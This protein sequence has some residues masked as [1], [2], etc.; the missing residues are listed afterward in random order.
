VTEFPISAIEADWSADNIE[1]DLIKQARHDR[2]AF[3][4]LY[5]RHYAPIA[6]YVYHRVGDAHTSEDL[7][8]EVFIAAM[9]SIRRYRHRG[10]P[11]RSWL[12][13]IATNTVNRWA[14][15]RQRANWF[16]SLTGADHNAGARVLSRTPPDRAGAR[17]F[18]RTASR[19]NPF[20]HEGR[21]D[22][23]AGAGDEAIL[24]RRA[25]LALPAHQQAVMALHYLEG[26]PLED[27]AAICGCQLGTVKSRLARGRESLRARLEQGR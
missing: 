27:V 2:G 25:L 10:L 18:S 13:R 9:K 5:R 15:K 21:S 14:R 12:Y 24:A 22:P 3:A 8:A 11:F 6:A 26:M 4:Q 7:V 1:R 23:S 16:A 19:G 17:I 20:P